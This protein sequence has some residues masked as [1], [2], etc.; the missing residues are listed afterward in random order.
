MMKAWSTVC[1]LVY[2][3]AVL[4][5]TGEAVAVLATYLMEV[6]LPIFDT[7]FHFTP[8]LVVMIVMLSVSAYLGSSNLISK[9][10]QYD[11]L[12]KKYDALILA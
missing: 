9:A 3:D 8:L 2:L 6:M 5:D 4:N 10:S 1:F 11:D 12:K 7:N